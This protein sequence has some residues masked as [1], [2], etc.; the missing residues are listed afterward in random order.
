MTDV[1][2]AELKARLSHYL[3]LVGTG[4]TITIRDRKT[5]V[6][7]IVPHAGEGE[8]GRL[9]IRRAVRHPSELELPPPPETPTNSLATLLEDRASR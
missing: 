3:R 9:E 4:R 1:G 6:A 7:R 2:I 8:D 5:A